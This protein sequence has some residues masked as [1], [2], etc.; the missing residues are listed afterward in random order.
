MSVITPWIRC[1]MCDGYICA[2]HG[3][4]HVSDCPCPPIEYWAEYGLH[5]YDENPRITIDVMLEETKGWEHEDEQI[6]N[7]V[8]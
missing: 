5:P 4:N 3:N 2:I 8:R 7:G 1:D 6:F